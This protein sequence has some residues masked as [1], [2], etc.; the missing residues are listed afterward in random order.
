MIGY[1]FNKT[2]YKGV[3]YIPKN[4]IVFG[5]DREPC[6]YDINYYPNNI[7]AYD[8]IWSNGNTI[9]KRRI[10]GNAISC[11]KLNIE[12]DLIKK[13]QNFCWGE[14]FLDIINAH[15]CAGEMF[16]IAKKEAE[17]YYNIE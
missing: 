14:D 3:L 1:Y 12:D 2:E 10:L 8:L 6:A 17:L 15:V 11:L 4:L 13:F 9:E 7:E 5:D 16:E